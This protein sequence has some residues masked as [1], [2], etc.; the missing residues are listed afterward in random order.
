MNIKRDNAIA[1]IDMVIA[2]IAIMIF[3]VLILSMITNNIL[4][5]LKLKNESMA[6]IYMT[7][8]FENV[9]I[10]AFDNEIYQNLTPDYVEITAENIL[11]SQEIIDKCKVEMSTEIIKKSDVESFTATFSDTVND[12]G[13]LRKVNLRLTYEVAGKEYTCSMQRMKIKE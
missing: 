8:I 3:S 12:D 13:V 5:N 9:G 6:M 11:V 2:I 4:E 10:V 7:E 1:G